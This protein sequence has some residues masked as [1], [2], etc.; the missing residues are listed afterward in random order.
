MIY[1]L[2][3]TFAIGAFAIIAKNANKNNIDYMRVW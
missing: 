3:T 1:L 2:L